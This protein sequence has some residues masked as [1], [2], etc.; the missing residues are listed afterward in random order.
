MTIISYYEDGSC[1][2]EEASETR[3]EWDSFEYIWED[4]SE[5]YVNLA[6]VRKVER[7]HWILLIY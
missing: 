3:D 1:D 2:I 7:R 6:D 5:I 4:W